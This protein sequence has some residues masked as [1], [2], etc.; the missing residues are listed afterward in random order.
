MHH[1]A[2]TP[3]TTLAGTA[4]TVVSSVSR[5]AASA[6]GSM[7]ALKKTV[8]PL[9]N[10]SAKTA[11]SGSSTKPARN[12]SA[13]PV[14]VQRTQSESRV[15]RVVCERGAALLRE[16]TAEAMAGQILWWRRVHFWSRLMSS[17]STNEAISMTTA[18]AVAPL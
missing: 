5:M 16:E 2:A 15:A 10:A 4:M 1:A 13:T 14:S 3:K 6:S 7:N 17:R 18:M 9:R 11:P 12:N 8:H